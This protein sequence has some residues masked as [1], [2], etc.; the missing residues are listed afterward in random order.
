MEK[1]VKG[2]VWC[3]RLGKMRAVNLMLEQATLPVPS[4]SAAPGTCILSW[5][6]PRAARLALAK[7]EMGQ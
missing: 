5:H 7:S 6:S 3:T 1:A 4:F 2:M